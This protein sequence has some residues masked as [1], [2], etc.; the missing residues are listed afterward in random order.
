MSDIIMPI[1]KLNGNI[2]IRRPMRRPRLRW[3]DNIRGGRR[4]AG[5]RD[6]WSRTI[7]E[8]RA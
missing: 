8:A 1:K 6:I 5:G 3:E 2:Y 4:L 7:E